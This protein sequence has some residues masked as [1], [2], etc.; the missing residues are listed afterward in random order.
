MW[1]QRSAEVPLLFHTNIH[2]NVI[3]PARHLL[4]LPVF[5][6]SKIYHLY[7]SMPSFA[8]TRTLYRLVFNGLL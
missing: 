1:P 7:V 4:P 8:I 2:R 5:C 3:E 6:D